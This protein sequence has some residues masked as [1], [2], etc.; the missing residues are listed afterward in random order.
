VKATP[1]PGETPSNVSLDQITTTS[2]RLSWKDNTTNETEFRIEKSTNGT[3]W[4]QIGTATA[5]SGTGSTVYY[6]G[7]G[8]SELTPNTRY[9]YRVQACGPTGAGYLPDKFYAAVLGSGECTDY[10]TASAKYTLAEAPTE[11]GTGIS[12]SPETI[13]LWKGYAPDDLYNPELHNFCNTQFYFSNSQGNSG[14]ILP[15]CSQD[16]RQLVWSQSGLTCGTTLTTSLKARNGDNIETGSVSGNGS[17]TACPCGDNSSCSESD[18]S[19][20]ACSSCISNG[21]GLT[22]GD[23]SG[24]CWNNKCCGDDSGENYRT[25]VVGSCSGNNCPSF[26]SDT[27]DK[28][29]C[30]L[31]SDCVYN[32]TCYSSGPPGNKG[33]GDSACTSANNW[34]DCDYYNSQPE[35]D[36][37]G[38]FC[39]KDVAK[40]GEVVGEYS[41]TNTTECCGDD[42]G[43][44]YVSKDCNNNNIQYGGTPYGVC[45]PSSKPNWNGSACVSTCG[46]PDLIVE[47]ISWSTPV[48]AGDSVTFT[49]TIKNQG[50]AQAGASVV[51][52]YIDD[53][54]LPSPND[55]DD[56]SALNAGVGSSQTFSWTAQGGSHTVKA[57]A[58]AN[59]QV[60][61]SNE[62]NNERTETVNVNRPPGAFNLTSP[63]NNATCVVTNPRL[64]WE[65]STD[66]DGNAVT[67]NVYLCSGSGCTPTYNGTAAANYYDLSGLSNN[68]IYRWN[69]AASDGSLSTNSS[70]GP[71]QFTTKQATPSQ[72]TGLS[73]GSITTSKITWSWNSVSGANYYDFNGSNIGNVTSYDYPTSGNANTSYTANVK[74]CS[75]CGDCSSAASLSKYT[76]ANPPSSCSGTA[77]SDTQINW[78]WNSGGAQKDFYASDSAGNTGWTTNTSWNQGSLTCNTS[79]TLSVKARNGDNVETNSATCSAS[80]QAC[81]D[82]TTK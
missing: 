35:W 82:T 56:V 41:D 75:S 74:A 8:M 79:Y 19:S 59:S 6:T 9:W 69:V 34:V 66:P 23:A 46:Q 76:A 18:Y 80:T 11:V 45:C 3:A 33:P 61:E 55:K 24:S 17:T 2:M 73:A 36:V 53:D 49:V 50:N 39:G 20:S 52:Y 38:D 81:P 78:S 65:V 77:A 26:S 14:W 12:G 10:G 42:S 1:L 54:L 63:T 64:Q 58:D 22:S 43:E 25:R 47:D 27:N 13:I 30:D 57:V 31:S 72:P 5:V 71:F 68:T 15:Q 60:S 48:N 32:G 44:T 28:A 29:C 16:N 62:G 37:C 7:T 4:T 21:W 67:Y 40:A 51:K 70:N